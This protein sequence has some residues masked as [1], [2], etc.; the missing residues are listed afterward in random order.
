MAALV[1]EPPARQTS[2]PLLGLFLLAVAA[3]LYIAADLLT[4]IAFAMLL[5]LLLS[6]LVR[7]LN[8]FG[9]PNALSALMI[10]AT[11]AGLLVLA[12]MA[13]AEPAERWLTEAPRTVRELKAEL[14][15]GKSHL[16]GIQELADEVEELAQPREPDDAQPVVVK[17]PSV[18]ENLLVGLPTAAAFIGLV[19]FLTFFLLASGDT[20]LRRMTRCGRTWTERRRI[21]LIA[22]QIQREQSRYL[23]TVTVI[24]FTLG[25][26]T[27]V[28]MYWLDVPNP[29]LWG[30]MVALFN[31]APY[32]GALASAAV[33]TVVGISTFDTLGDSLA[34]AAVFLVLTILEG[35]LITPTILGQRMS[36]SPLF[37]FLAVIVW[38]WLWGIAGALMAVPI[39]T[40]LKVI[41]DHVPRLKYIGDFARG[42]EPR[43]P[44]A[45]EPAEEQRHVLR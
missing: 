3:C 36:L 23:A 1:G 15:S 30:T 16:E 21:V 2:L 33:L 31:F 8:R 25:A 5:N 10:V 13:L 4:P 29:I 41:C 38:G 17:G 44:P 26:V 6:P 7:G 19:M 18:T 45:A 24:N 42:E 39:V 27:G 32:V 37:V 35:Q 9:L 43:L 22:R 20:L 11:L 34:P 28:A 12:I 40:S 14:F